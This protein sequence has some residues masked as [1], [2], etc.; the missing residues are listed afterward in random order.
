MGHTKKKYFFNGLN[1]NTGFVIRAFAIRRLLFATKILDS[2]IFHQ[3]CQVF[4]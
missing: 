2:R 1:P 3:F 4:L